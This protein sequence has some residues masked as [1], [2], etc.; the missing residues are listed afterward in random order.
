MQIKS[1]KSYIFEVAFSG[2]ENEYKKE[3]ALVFF[4]MHLD[5]TLD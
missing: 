2:F 4:L 3:F 1:N 5:K